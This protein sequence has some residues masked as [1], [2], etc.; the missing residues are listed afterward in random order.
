MFFVVHTSAIPLKTDNSSDESYE[1]KNDLFE[2]DLK[3]P[4]EMILKHYN[5]SSIPGGEKIQQKYFENSS[6]ARNISQASKDHM[7][8]KRAA[9]HNIGLWSNN[10]VR[11][12]ISSDISATVA[13]KIREAMNNF[14]NHTCLRFIADSRASD[15]IDFINTDEGCYSYLGRRGGRQVINLESPGCNSVGIIIHEIA[16]AIG[17]WH[18]QSR[19]D[20]DR[21]VMIHNNNIIERY[22]DQ[23]MKR[24]DFD[25]DYQGS[26]Y[27]YGSIMHYGRNAFKKTGC[28]ASSCITISV[29]NLT[30]YNL[31]GRPYLG[32]RSRLSAEDI[33]QTN[34]LYS[35]AK[36]GIR[37]FLTIHVKRGSSLR[38][39]DWIF[40]NPDP[41][42]VLTAV[43]SQGTQYRRQ[44]SYKQGRRH[45]VWNEFILLGEREWQFFRISAW[46]DD[47]GSDDQLTMSQTVPI[48]R[49]FHRDLRHCENT[50]CNGYVVYDYY[51]DTR[52]IRNARLKVKILF[53]RNLVDT[54]T[55]WNRPDPYVRI[56]AIQ[57]NA[58]TQ[59][60]NSRVIS[61]STNPTWNQWIDYGCQRWNSMII[62]VMD[63]DIWSDDIMSD[64]QLW[65]VYSGIHFN[66]RQA[67][68]GSGYL[69]FDYNLI[70]DGNECS[71]NLCQ[72]RGSCVDRCT[73]YT[74]HCRHGY[75]G[76]NCQY[77][78]GYLR[79]TARYGR[80]LPDEDGWWN[81]SDPYMEFIAVDV[82]GNSVRRTTRHLQGDHNPNWNQI[83][84]FGYRAWRSLRVK[85]YDS[86]FNSDDALSN[87]QTFWLSSLRTLS[88]L[89]HNCHR[90]YTIFD[91][92]YY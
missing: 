58:I 41:Y 13:T 79:V 1:T 32:Q 14:E 70:V 91:Y 4:I 48:K 74:C 16:H 44:T 23:F 20:R 24:N 27:D 87:Q 42:V 49:G 92:S 26:K 39:T 88:N 64:R 66:L 72:N 68:H 19:P 12:R 3:I 78:A 2:G 17:F 21:Y 84:Y 71:P 40:N 90:G 38:D 30:E 77:F 36:T 85:V 89:R 47:V 9:G 50:G 31:Q 43:D 75:T 54:D 63:D 76:T 37:G 82:F 83:L 52:T 7:Y 33:L 18:E 5:F 10:I 51:F 60:R 65:H 6:Y 62:Q 35:C 25:V 69:M 15:Y 57:S 59:T 29:N 53:A 22:T 11:Y 45:P 46:D 28:I 55:I 80:N 73:G 81:D 67:A 86:D 34:R 61:G 8:N 56:E